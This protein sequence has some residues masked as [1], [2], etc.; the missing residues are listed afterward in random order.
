VLIGQTVTY[1]GRECQ[2]RGFTPAGVIPATVDIEDAET[3]EIRT[4]LIER[5]RARLRLVD[6]EPDAA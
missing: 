3:G 6:P 4:V 1:A 2:I 5:L